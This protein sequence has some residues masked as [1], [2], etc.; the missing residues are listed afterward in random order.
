MKRLTYLLALA[1]LS[2]LV[3]PSSHTGLYKTPQRLYFVSQE[4]FN[5]TSHYRTLAKCLWPICVCMSLSECWCFWECMS[6]FNRICVCVLVHASL[7]VC[8]CVC[9]CVCAHVCVCVCGRSWQR[10]GFGPKISTHSEKSASVFLRQQSMAKK[11][12]YY[13]LIIP[14]MHYALIK[15]GFII[16]LSAWQDDP[17]QRKGGGRSCHVNKQCELLL[18]RSFLLPNVVLG[19]WCSANE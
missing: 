8:V 10:R 9:I 12:I 15:Y 18:P 19:L 4:S 7:R 11:T 17:T 2:P 14:A 1:A 16:M 13:A 3:S 5:I 6:V